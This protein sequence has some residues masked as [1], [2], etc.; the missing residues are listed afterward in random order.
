MPRSR[1]CCCVGLTICILLK[2][3]NVFF[4][5]QIIEREPS[6]KFQPLAFAKYV[7]GSCWERRAYRINHDS[8]NTISG[9]EYGLDD[10]GLGRNKAPFKITPLYGPKKATW[11]QVGL[12]S[13]FWPAHS[14]WYTG[15][16]SF[17]DIIVQHIQCSTRTTFH[18]SC[19]TRGRKSLGAMKYFFLDPIGRN[20]WP[21]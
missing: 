13:N 5:R 10:V 19:E 1:C 18:A 21:I 20:L 6:L 17:D 12:S 15:P 14:Y 8:A 2:V 16:V 11:N 3:Y 4:P 9:L 7:I